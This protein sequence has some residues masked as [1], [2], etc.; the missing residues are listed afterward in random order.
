MLLVHGSSAPMSHAITAVHVTATHPK[1]AASVEPQE[2]RFTRLH[3]RK[4][5][6]M[7]SHGVASNANVPLC[8]VAAKSCLRSCC[9]SF[10]CRY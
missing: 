9:Q 5:A 6:S 1:A 10:C 2:R 4:Q 3:S 7:A 8:D